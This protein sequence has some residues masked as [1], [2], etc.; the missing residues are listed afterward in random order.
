M[1]NPKSVEKPYSMPVGTLVRLKRECL[2]NPIGV[3][4]V[5]YEDY[6][7]GVSVIFENGRYDGFSSIS[8]EAFGNLSDIEFILFI[9]GFCPS[10]ASYEFKNVGTLER[11][12]RQGLFSEAFF[13]D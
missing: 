5:V 7:S 6:G 12:F 1:N 4:G 10:I 3:K 11:D 13:F 8:S 2:G 9:D